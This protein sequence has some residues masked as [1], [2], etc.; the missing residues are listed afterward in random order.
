M[1]SSSIVSPEATPTPSG[2]DGNGDVD[3]FDVDDFDVDVEKMAQLAASRFRRASVNMGIPQQDLEVLKPQVQNFSMRNRFQRGK[4]WYSELDQQLVAQSF[5]E[6]TTLKG[7]ASENVYEWYETI[8][9]DP[10]SGIDPIELAKFNRSVFMQIAEKVKPLQKLS[11]IGL[12]LRIFFCLLLSYQD[13]VTDILVSIDFYAKGEVE[14]F[15]LSIGFVILASFCHVGLTVLLTHKMTFIKRMK[16]VLAAF[17]LLNPLID[18]YSVWTGRTQSAEDAMDPI[19]R[20][21]LSRAVELLAESLPE[22]ILQMYILFVTPMSDVSTLQ[23][24]SILSSILAFGYTVTDTSIQV[25]QTE[26]FRQIRGPY[27]DTLHGLLPKSNRGGVAMQ[28]AHFLFS[29]SYF[30]T[31]VLALVAILVTY[32]PGACLLIGLE[33]VAFLVVRS[34]TRNGLWQGSQTVRMSNL[35]SL[36]ICVVSYFAIAYAPYFQARHPSVIGGRLFFAG[37]LLKITSNIILYTSCGIALFGGSRTYTGIDLNSYIL[38]FTIPA[39]MTVTSGMLVLYLCTDS[40]RHTLWSP[41]TG[42]EFHN[43]QFKGDYICAAHL[44]VDAQRASLLFSIHPHFYDLDYVEHW[45][46][47]WDVRDELFRHA[48]LPSSISTGLT[49]DDL[50]DQVNVIF[51]KHGKND[52]VKAAV[53]KRVESFRAEIQEQL[54]EEGSF[55]QGSTTTRGEK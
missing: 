32:W 48:T 21:L 3:D 30:A 43:R 47:R 54:L 28:I 34:R 13:M 7:N 25:E 16:R 55:R 15:A 24:F 51:E 52:Q 29:T 19:L 8:M 53:R 35:Y 49:H 14:W 40:H 42:F 17:L 9:P 6:F 45:I 12:T 26:M 18:G 20:L 2:N 5:F 46:M 38:V 33:L 4:K 11:R 23:I 22:A 37:I 10:E 36:L 44:T 41:E 27:S 31:S 1:A 39:I 50:F